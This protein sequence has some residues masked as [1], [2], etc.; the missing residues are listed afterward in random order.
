MKPVFFFIFLATLFFIPLQSNSLIIY[1]AY[2][3]LY[4][5]S[6]EWEEPDQAESPAYE[7]MG[8]ESTVLPAYRQIKWTLDG[9]PVSTPWYK[10]GYSILKFPLSG[11]TPF[12][13]VTLH[14]YSIET[15]KD[16]NLY[17]NEDYFPG[18]ISYDE[19]I[20]KNT[21][22]VNN[23]PNHEGWISLDI[24]DKTQVDFLLGREATSWRISFDNSS[25]DAYGYYASSEDI[26]GRKPYI[27]VVPE[28]SGLITLS[29]AVI[30]WSSYVR[31]RSKTRPNRGYEVSNLN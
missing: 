22:F 2:D 15:S 12:D 16:I 11:L 25:L 4:G 23:F 28:P 29:L 24:T 6:L 18:P 9:S 20:S 3:G 17:Y 31:K 10:Y 26:F 1:P 21:S 14:I 27:E 8:L 7:W 5:Y 19:F 30:S 13:R